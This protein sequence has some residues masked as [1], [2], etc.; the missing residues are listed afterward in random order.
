MSHCGAIILDIRS[1]RSYT[2]EA[3][4]NEIHK[5]IDNFDSFKSINIYA[6]FSLTLLFCEPPLKQYLQLCKTERHTDYIKLKWSEL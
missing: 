1:V 3:L 2:L 4:S 5:K 6:L